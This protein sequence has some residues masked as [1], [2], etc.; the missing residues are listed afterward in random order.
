ML[1]QRHAADRDSR[2]NDGEHPYRRLSGGESAGKIPL[3]P[4]DLLGYVPGW[5]GRQHAKRTS[6]TIATHCRRHSSL[7]DK[8]PAENGVGVDDSVNSVASEFLAR[9]LSQS[10][11]E[12]ELWGGESTIVTGGAEDADCAQRAGGEGVGH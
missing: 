12:S 2:G 6:T 3:R 7:G 4:R 9:L 10:G 1:L 11:E 8:A 5:S